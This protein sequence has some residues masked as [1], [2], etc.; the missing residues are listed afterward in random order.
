M[1]R[2]PAWYKA[3]RLASKNR[4]FMCEKWLIRHAFNMARPHLLPQCVL[5]RTKETFSDRLS[6]EKDSFYEAINKHVNSQV[7][8]LSIQTTHCPPSTVEA[9]YYRSKFHAF[10]GWKAASVIPRVWM[11]MWVNTSDPSARSMKEVYEQVQAQ[12]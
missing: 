1:L 2:I 5:W 8:P 3:P 6:T 10:F 12:K 7:V 11:P 9:C 4:E